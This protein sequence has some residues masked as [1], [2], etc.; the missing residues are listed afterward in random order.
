CPI[1]DSTR[2][3]YST[4]NG[5]GS[6]SKIWI[7]DF[8][9]WWN[10]FDTN[11]EFVALSARDLQVHCDLQAFPNLRVYINPGGDAYMQL[12]SLG[13]AGTDNIKAFVH[14][15]QRNPSAYVGICAG[16]YLAAHDYIWETMYQGAD[17]Y[18]FATN[19]PMSLFPHT[20]EG[21]IFD[22]NDDQ[23]GDQSGSKFRVV[24]VS[25]GHHML[26]YGGSTFGYNGV[27]DYAD[28]QSPEYDEDIEGSVNFNVGAWR[29]GNLL[30]SSVHPEASNCTD[31][32]D[33][34][35]PPAGTLPMARIWQNWAWLS[36]YIN[37]VSQSSFLIP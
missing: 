13:V 37:E 35:C 14:R 1:R 36:T 8:L 11:V 25:N 27:P 21:S 28:P 24:N 22:I 6:G 23:F 12:S 15:D 2:V 9:E 19:P 18:D 29:Y 17:Y 5:V 31:H 26:Y 20:V 10:T 16:T 7:A 4:V 33:V 32:E 34:D 30:L 3:V